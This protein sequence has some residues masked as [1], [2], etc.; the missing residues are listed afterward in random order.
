MFAT[1]VP[2]VEEQDYL[3]IISMHFIYQCGLLFVHK[4]HDCI[5][6][7]TVNI[8]FIYASSSSMGDLVCAEYTHTL[9]HTQSLSQ[10]FIVMIYRYNFEGF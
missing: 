9:T 10:C 6:D 5:V 4:I 1:I 3:S 7:C 8:K 2:Y